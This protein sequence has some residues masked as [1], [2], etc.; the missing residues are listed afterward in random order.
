MPAADDLTPAEAAELLSVSRD[1]IY[2]LVQQ[3]RLACYRPGLGRGKILI[4]RAAAISC[5][6]R[7]RPTVFSGRPTSD[8]RPLWAVPAIGHGDTAGVAW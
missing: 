6:T 1:L 4:P 3:G 8:G 2:K 7:E 5:R